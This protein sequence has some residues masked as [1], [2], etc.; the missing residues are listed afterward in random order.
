MTSFYLRYLERVQQVVDLLPLMGGHLKVSLPGV[1][2]TISSLSFTKS[3]E[4]LRRKSR[5]KKPKSQ[6]RL[7]V[8]LLSPPNQGSRWLKVAE[9]VAL[10]WVTLLA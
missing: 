10:D 7:L 4:R 3:E 6:P 1:G 8:L 5:R 9:E 2:I